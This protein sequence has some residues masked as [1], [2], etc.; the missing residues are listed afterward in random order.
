[1]ATLPSVPLGES[2]DL[3]FDFDNALPDI[4]RFSIEVTYFNSTDDASLTEPSVSFDN[5][6]FTTITNNQ[7]DVP[8]GKKFFTIRARLN[9]DPNTRADDSVQVKVVPITNTHLIT[10][11]EGFVAIVELKT[12]SYKTDITVD[13]LAGTNVGEGSTAVAVYTFTPAL[14]QE[15]LLDFKLVFNGTASNDDIG[16]LTYKVDS[17]TSKSLAV[18]EQ[19]TLPIGAS[20]L[21]IFVPVLNDGF[22][23]PGEGVTVSILEPIGQLYTKNRT[24]VTK[25]FVFTDT[26]VPPAGTFLKYICAGLD[27]YGQYAD[28]VGGTYQQLIKKNSTDCGYVIPPAGTLLKTLCA[29]YDK[30]GEYADGNDGSYFSIIALEDSS[31][32]FVAD[33]PNP[34]TELVPTKFDPA[35][36]GTTVTLSN[37]DR[38]F[39]GDNRDMARTEFSA[40]YGKWY[41]E[42][43][44][45][46]PSDKQ[47]P[48]AMGVVTA[49][50]AIGNWIGSDVYSWAW[51]PHEGT[52]FY[53]DKQEFYGPSLMDGDVVGIL[54]NI[55]EGK[56]SF[57]LN[58]VDIGVM[59]DNLTPFVPL[60]FATSSLDSSFA[61]VNFGQTLFKYPVPAGYY[62]GFG[63]PANAPLPRRTVVNHFCTGVDRWVTLADGK[64]G[65]FTE[66]EKVNDTDCGYVPPPPAAGTIIGY[67]CQG[68]DYYAIVADGN[69]GSTKR[70]ESI[71]SRACGYTPPPPP[72]FTPTTLD[73]NF[74]STGTTID[75]NGYQAVP[76]GTVRTVASVYSGKWSWEVSSNTNFGL[77]GITDNE[78]GVNAMIGST[79]KSYALD[80]ATGEIVNAGVRKAFTTPIDAGAIVGVHLDFVA[81]KL[82]FSVNGVLI[83]VAFDIARTTYFAAASSSGAATLTFNMGDGTQ[84]YTVPQDHVSGFGVASTIYYQK[85]TYLTYTCSGTTINHRFADGGGGYYTTS[86]EKSPTC[87]YV[88]PKPAGTIVREFCQATDKYTE[89]NDGNYG[90]YTTLTETKSIACGYK[91]FGALISTYCASFTKMGIY[92]DGEN[93]S[94]SAPIEEFSRECGYN[95][96]GSGGS[97]ETT[98]DPNLQVT[99]DGAILFDTFYNPASVGEVILRVE[100]T[101]TPPVSY[102]TADTVIGYYCT[103][104]SKT[105][106]LANGSG[107]SYTKNIGY[108]PD[109]GPLP[110]FTN[111]L[112]ADARKIEDSSTL[113]YAYNS[114][115]LAVDFNSSMYNTCFIPTTLPNKT[116]ASLDLDIEY[117][118]FGGVSAP[119]VGF[120][121]F[122]SNNTFN[123]GFYFTVNKTESS[124][125]GSNTSVASN[126]LLVPGYELPANALPTSGRQVLTLIVQPENGYFRF[127]FKVNG[128]VV[129]S[130]LTNAAAVPFSPGIYL[131]SV[132][133]IIYDFTYSNY[134]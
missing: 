95:V 5:S 26:Y 51:W 62:P 98:I 40:M 61:R 39:A 67:E 92:S 75:S 132:A 127:T 24:P 112:A 93:G 90:T 8:K 59:Y 105:V 91:P 9:N 131:R 111:G 130:V 118:A 44:I 81:E 54:L 114:S 99:A 1:M 97:S 2:V 125:S 89:Y 4:V 107:G 37:G 116:S 15:T 20:K 13:A 42:Q 77:I 128:V 64:G 122:T 28:G 66:L 55:Q 78:V 87:G 65:T 58:G 115:K 22:S 25:T 41:I 88:P 100:N 102:P 134:P 18:K 56:I 79:A 69:Y 12:V 82:S 85:G 19:L 57:Q 120:C 68:Y 76:V 38:N 3:V 46:L 133:G 74:K 73:T 32:G 117:S 86:I 27:Q 70:L 126:S 17:G 113:N 43:T 63:V 72:V 119:G 16:P 47:R 101:R 11:P 104:K 53:N 21:E 80:L 52:K 94:F 129:H 109:C 60:Y 35:N 110:F 103:G 121:L 6:T 124:Y 14:Q 83:G 71:N 30:I 7:F 106:Q 34:Q 50:H 45:L 29:G 23:D 123:C 33:P 108:D 10:N 31:C 96:G 36:K 48:T 84:A 49:S